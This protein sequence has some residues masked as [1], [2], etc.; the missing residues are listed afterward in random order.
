VI[1]GRFR[2][3]ARRGPLALTRTERLRGEGPFANRFEPV[4]QLL[5]EITL[6]PDG[7]PA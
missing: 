7:L 3:S 6:N 2:R 4:A 1:S 5:F